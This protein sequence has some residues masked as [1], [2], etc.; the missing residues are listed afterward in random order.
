VAYGEKVLAREKIN[1]FGEFFGGSPP[2]AMAV[3]SAVA[4]AMTMAVRDARPAHDGANA[5][6]DNGAYGTGNQRPGAGSDRGARDRSFA[7]RCMRRRQ[8][9]KGSGDARD[10]NLAHGPVLHL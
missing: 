7:C 10:E 4:P 3:A 5:A 1:Y 9:Q 2:P 8:R 6:A